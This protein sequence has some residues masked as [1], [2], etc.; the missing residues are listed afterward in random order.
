MSYQFTG[1]WQIVMALKGASY[2]LEH[3]S[4]P[5]R[6]EKKHVSDLFHYPM[7][8]I[9]FQ[10]LDGPDTWYGQIHKPITAQPFKEAGINGFHPTL[11]YKVP[12]WFLTTDQA[13]D[14]HWPSLLALND[15][16]LPFPR[17][18]EE[19]RR[20]YLA[21]NTIKT[22]QAMYT[23]PPPSSL[24]YSTPTIPPLNILTRSIIQSS[25]KL[26]FITNSIRLN[27]AHE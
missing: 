12:A 9:P 3:C 26:F 13:S 18:S 20:H 6:K 7:E 15:D 14:F 5:N 22:L 21:G 27:D 8:L 25:D 19:E 1:P 11:P 16:L 23:G 2:E 24:E 17:S 4:T 10:P